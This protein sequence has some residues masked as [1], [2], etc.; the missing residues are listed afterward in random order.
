ML[1]NVQRIGRDGDMNKYIDLVACREKQ[2]IC[3]KHEARIY[4]IGQLY[5]QTEI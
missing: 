4:I 1:E 5:A 3:M 2:V